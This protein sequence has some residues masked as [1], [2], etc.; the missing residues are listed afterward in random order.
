MIKVIT[1]YWILKSYTVAFMKFLP[2]L[3]LSTVTTT[4]TA[5]SNKCPHR[6]QLVLPPGILSAILVN[7]GWWVSNF[8]VF[9]IRL[10]CSLFSKYHGQTDGQMEKWKI[11]KNSTLA[12]HC[13]HPVPC[14]FLGNIQKCIISILFP[15]TRTRES[16]HLSKMSPWE[17]RTATTHQH[18]QPRPRRLLIRPCSAT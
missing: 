9:I 12:M 1:G 13:K 4:T 7:R 16:F 10:V 17:K 6:I 14:P 18:Q 8:F 3:V 15:I 11:L 5:T 2:Q